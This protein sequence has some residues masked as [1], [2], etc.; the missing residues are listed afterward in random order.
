MSTRVLHFT[1]G[2]IQDFIFQARRTRDLWG[3]SFMLSWLSGIA[4]TQ[5]IKATGYIEF[6]AVHDDE[7]NPTDA[8]LAAIIGTPFLNNPQPG[9]GSLPTRFKAIV[10]TGFDPATQVTDVVQ[11]TFEDAAEMVWREYVAHA[12]KSGSGTR[13]IWER[14]VQNFW[15]YSWVLGEHPPDRTDLLWLDARKNWRMPAGTAQEGG[16]HC[17]VMHAWQEL[18]GWVRACEPGKQNKF[19]TEIRKKVGRLDLR[20]DERLCA[21]AFVKR[22]L[23]KLAKNNLISKM[24]QLSRH[25]GR[26]CRHPEH[27]DVLRPLPSVASGFRQSLPERRF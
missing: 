2:P 25:I 11:K 10:P 19:W 1:I 22:M 27:R 16:D 21:I 18:S 4:M 26:D 3:G 15:E 12:V 6:P 24:I 14:Q 23:P 5:V 8:L 7:R 20:P 13:A 17:T 9:I